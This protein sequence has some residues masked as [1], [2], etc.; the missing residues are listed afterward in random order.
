MTRAERLKRIQDERRSKVPPEILNAE[1]A[2]SRV[3]L[4]IDEIDEHIKNLKTQII[5][6]ENR[7]RGKFVSRNRIIKNAT[8]LAIQNRSIHDTKSAHVA[9]TRFAH[10][11]RGNTHCLENDAIHIRY[12]ADKII[13]D[14]FK[15]RMKTAVDKYMGF[16]APHIVNLIAEY[17]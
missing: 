11:L 8:I 5:E 4:E 3:H 6:A 15:I 13:I 2:I 17:I 14:Y 7:R 10:C 12:D 1:G 9:W 16:F